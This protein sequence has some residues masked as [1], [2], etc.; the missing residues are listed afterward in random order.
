M[1]K[2]DKNKCIDCGACAETC[3]GVFEMRGDGKAYVKTDADLKKNAKCLKE[4]IDNCAVE[5]IS[6]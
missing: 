2:I 3:P 4:A 5:A 6:K 1:V